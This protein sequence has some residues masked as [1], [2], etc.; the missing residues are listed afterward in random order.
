MYSRSTYGNGFPTSEYLRSRYIVPEHYDGVAFSDVSGPEK[1]FTNNSVQSTN[2]VPAKSMT[3]QPKP[4]PIYFSGIAKKNFASPYSF[5]EQ[6][7]PEEEKKQYNDETNEEIS[8]DDCD[9]ERDCA[10]CGA[11]ETN[12]DL[13][14]P[15]SSNCRGGKSGLFSSS[16]S[17][18][19]LLLA[20]VVLILMSGGEKG[21]ND[22][23]ILLLIFLMFL[24]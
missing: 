12:S 24:H 3:P 7:L 5:S 15:V 4:T 2:E 16:F 23:L 19:D 9:E 10:A 1:T 8:D 17:E 18:E 20:A 21:E 22:D 14:K 11:D 13:A 6:K